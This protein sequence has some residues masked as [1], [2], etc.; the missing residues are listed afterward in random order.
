MFDR[1]N[2]TDD[3]DVA[4]ALRQVGEFTGLTDARGDR[5]VE[6]MMKQTFRK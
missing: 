1:Y 6:G 3:T 2:I 4:Q 5:A